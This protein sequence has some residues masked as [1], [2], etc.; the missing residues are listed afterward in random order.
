MYVTGSLCVCDCARA[1]TDNCVCVPS[2]LHLDGTVSA[3]LLRESQS[4]DAH[5]V[6]AVSNLDA[7]TEAWLTG[8]CAALDDITASPLST[9][10]RSD[11]SSLSAEIAAALN[12]GVSRVISAVSTTSSVSDS[13]IKR[14]SSSRPAASPYFSSHP[15][16]VG[17]RGRS[18]GER[19]FGLDRTNSITA[20]D[21]S[22]SVK[23]VAME[24]QTRRPVH[25]S[26]GRALSKIA[27]PPNSP[28]TE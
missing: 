12:S 28:A 22:E 6:S 24:K 10:G 3:E 8:A 26:P 9:G 20:K 1:H 16:R 18:V 11:R 13:P 21:S 4:Q 14:A 25:A 2:T 17:K 5:D 23:R 15:S 19:S 7:K 27:P